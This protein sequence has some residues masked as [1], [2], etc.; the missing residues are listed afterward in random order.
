M[1]SAMVNPDDV[2]GSVEVDGDSP[3]LL[4]GRHRVA[5]VT[6]PWRSASLACRYT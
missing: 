2:H 5:I 6:K 4:A 1:N 3:R